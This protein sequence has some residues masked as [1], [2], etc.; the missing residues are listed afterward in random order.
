MSGTFPAS[1]APREVELFQAAPALV[2]QAHSMKTQR[3][4]RGG[5]RWGLR[6]TYAPLT[7]A[8]W[9][10]IFAFGVKQRGR[11]ETFQYVLPTPLKTPLG[12]ATGTPTVNN[13]SGSPEELQT[14]S[15]NVA[16]A[17][18]T[19]GVTGIVKAGDFLLYA[20]HS[21]VYMAVADANSDGSGLATIQQEPALYE[22]P[23]HG[24]AITIASPAF[25]VAFT[26]DSLR[27]V[28]RLRPVYD[29]TIELIE[30]Y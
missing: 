20:G 12:V 11:Y 17:G 18:W 10:P 14:G 7:R 29:M 22:G 4:S 1:P 9:A 13:Q 16:T 8:Q 5:Q 28:Q 24:A 26:E 3:R 2:S 30:V 25:T 15:R 23:A 27:A 21:K 6:L 19:A